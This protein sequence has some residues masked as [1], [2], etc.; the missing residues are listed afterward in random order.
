[1]LNL[2]KLDLSSILNGWL[3]LKIKVLALKAYILTKLLNSSYSFPEQYSAKHIHRSFARKEEIS[4]CLPFQAAVM[5][6]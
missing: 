2:E 5:H 1:M 6:L 3:F 4:I